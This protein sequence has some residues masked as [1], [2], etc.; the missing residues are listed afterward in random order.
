MTISVSRFGQHDNFLCNSTLCLPD[1]ARF[2]PLDE[3]NMTERKTRE[4]RWAKF[5]TKV[6]LDSLR[7][8]KTISEVS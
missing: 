5:K 8:I 2:Q 4:V 1:L 3:A 7:G 6:R